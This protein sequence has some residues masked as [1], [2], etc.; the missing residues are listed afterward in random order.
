MRIEC[1]CF[2]RCSLCTLLNIR[3]R[4]RLFSRAPLLNK[5]HY[6]LP[7]VDTGQRD[8]TLDQGKRFFK[9]DESWFLFHYADDQIRVPRLPG[10]HFLPLF[11][12]GHKHSDGDIIMFRRTFSWKIHRIL[13]V[14]DQ[15]MEAANYLNIIE[16]QLH[17]YMMSAFHMEIESS[18]RIMVQVTVLYL[19]RVV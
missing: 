2:R 5:R 19:L 1:K 4:C 11:T 9:S 8:W 3:L 15:T 16:D 7:T 14:V 12:A 6:L 17:T 18:S 10:T 13:V